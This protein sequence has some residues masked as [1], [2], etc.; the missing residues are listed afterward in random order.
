MSR[1]D[2]DTPYWVKC[3]WYKAIHHYLCDLRDCDL[4]QEP[5]RR[6]PIISRCYWKPDWYYHNWRVSVP[7]WYRDHIWINSKRRQLR[8][9][10]ISAKKE[11]NSTK[12]TNVIPNID[13]HRHCA[14]WLWG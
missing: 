6:K 5:V 13:Q 4:P 11:Y 12:D 8:D 1:T 14:W 2:K 9:Q 10:L 3:E 7:K